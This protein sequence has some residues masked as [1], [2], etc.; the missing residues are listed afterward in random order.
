M[1]TT[2]SRDHRKILE[3]VVAQARVAA[4]VGAAK[5]LQALAVAAKDAPAHATE[6]AIK[7]RFT[8]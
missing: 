5:A 8:F 7:H 1:K 2:L 3:T 6:L 4:K